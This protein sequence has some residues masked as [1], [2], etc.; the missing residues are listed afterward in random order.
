MTQ[1][2][3]SVGPRWPC[4]SGCSA[5]K[6]WGVSQRLE[7]RRVS[8]QEG[9]RSGLTGASFPEPHSPA[10]RPVLALD[11]FGRDRLVRRQR[12]CALSAP[13]LAQPQEGDRW[14]GSCE[15]PE[16]WVTLRQREPSPPVA[17]PL[18][19]G[20]LTFTGCGNPKQTVRKGLIRDSDAHVLRKPPCS[21]ADG[22][23][24]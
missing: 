18:G 8:V 16:Q 3:S 17:P 10:M 24:V 21:H 14:P 13:A 1:L 11:M 6:P 5:W 20:R 19:S 2:N 23:F 12:P 22:W 4:P 9:S 15:R 7:A